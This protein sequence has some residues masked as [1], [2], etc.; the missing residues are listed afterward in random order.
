MAVFDRP[1]VLP[2]VCRQ[3]SRAHPHNRVVEACAT[4]GWY[5]AVTDQ[6]VDRLLLLEG[7]GRPDP[8]A[9]QRCQ[10]L[11]CIESDLQDDRSAIIADPI[12]LPSRTGDGCW[13]WRADQVKKNRCC[14]CEKRRFTGVFTG[15]A[16]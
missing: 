11:A 7:C 12:I 16:F 2:R 13:S 9:D 6:G 1:G 10:L 4:I 5:R 15:V 14:T 3:L 8:F